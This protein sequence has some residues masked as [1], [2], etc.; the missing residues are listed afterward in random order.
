MGI[1][2]GAQ[3]AARWVAVSLGIVAIHDRAMSNRHYAN[4][5]L[6]LGELVDNAERAHAQ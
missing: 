2:T 1:R 3:A 4:R 5:S 6:I